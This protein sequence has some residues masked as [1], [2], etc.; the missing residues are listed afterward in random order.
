[1]V[2]IKNILTKRNIIAAIL[3][4]LTVLWMAF[5]F[6]MSAQSGEESGE[7][8]GKVIDIIAETVVPGFSDMTDAEKDIARAELSFPIRKMA[9][10]TEYGILGALLTVSF[11]FSGKKTSVTCRKLTAA[12]SVG[13]L[14]AMSD[15]LHQKFVS[16]RAGMITDVFI[17]GSGVIAGCAVMALLIMFV[18]KRINRNTDLKDCDR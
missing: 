17:D 15:E 8:S 18:L 16:G 11:A 2:I 14:Y 1:M 3:W 13:W 6:G 10:F 5:I 4:C 12:L 7:T 9:H